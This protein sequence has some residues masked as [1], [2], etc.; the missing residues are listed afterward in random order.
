MEYGSTL[1]ILLLLV[2]IGWTEATP[3]IAFTLRAGIAVSIVA[4]AV[5]QSGV[6]FTSI[7]ITTI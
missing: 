6:R 3:V 1:A 5:Q 7:S 4:A 2:V